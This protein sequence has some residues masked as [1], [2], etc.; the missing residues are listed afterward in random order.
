MGRYDRIVQGKMELTGELIAAAL[1]KLWAVLA[2]LAGSATACWILRPQSRLEA[3]ATVS[4]GFFASIFV[5]PYLIAKWFPA[6]KGS[7]P[8]VALTYYGAGMVAM[9]IIPII[10]RRLVKRVSAAQVVE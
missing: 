4:C 9:F 7:A 10:I 8:E 1:S 2:A 5:A 3:I 6:A